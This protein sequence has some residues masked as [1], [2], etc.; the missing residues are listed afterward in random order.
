MAK[1]S[2]Q[3]VRAPRRTAPPRKVPLRE[4]RKK[5]HK[6]F[7]IVL[8]IFILSLIALAYY[9]L[10]LPTLRV[11]D[12]DIEGGSAPTDVRTSAFSAI[13]CVHWYGVPRNSIFALPDADI[14]SRIL[15]DFPG[16]GA[17]SVQPTSFEAITITITPRAGALV[18]CGVSID[19][20]RADGMCFDAD[21]EGLVFGPTSLE[22]LQASSTLRIFAPLDTDIGEGSPV[23]THVVHAAQIPDAL[24]FV[25]LLR[26]LGAPVSA[27]SIQQDEADL[28]LQGPTRIRY[29]LGREDIAAQLAASALPTL[30]LTNNSIEYID[31]RFTGEPGAPGKVYVKRFGE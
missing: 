24:R 15:E 1:V 18:W 29:V 10:W 21:T 7:L 31:L 20:P 28:Y 17:V 4:E 2:P 9:I 6:R 22:T 12:I 26:N 19:V 8:G 14:R 25:K 27:L 5:Q 13:E 3:V 16:I 11:Y 23:R 30:N